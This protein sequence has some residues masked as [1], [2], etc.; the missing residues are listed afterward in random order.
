MQLENE[1]ILMQRWQFTKVI[2]EKFIF[3]LIHSGQL[4]QNINKI[5]IFLTDLHYRRQY[6]E[7][8]L[9]FISFSFF[10]MNSWKL[11][12]KWSCLNHVMHFL[13]IE[14][15]FNQLNKNQPIA[16]FAKIMKNLS[17]HIR[18]TQNISQ[19]LCNVCICCCST[20]TCTRQSNRVR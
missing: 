19:C 9:R 8:F 1:S 4:G 10:D 13:L 20:I 7:P 2:S 6:L 18:K 12:P 11:S 14:R 16:N 5:N 3:V 17:L 15:P